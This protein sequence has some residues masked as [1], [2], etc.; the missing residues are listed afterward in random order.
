MRAIGGRDRG[1]SGSVGLDV[2]H[3]GQAP[4]PG[5]GSSCPWAHPT[6][7]FLSPFIRPPDRRRPTRLGPL[8]PVAPRLPAAGRPWRR[9]RCPAAA[10]PAARRRPRHPCRDRRRSAPSARRPAA[11]R[12][13]RLRVDI[14][15]HPGRPNHS[16]ADRVVK[17]PSATSISGAAGSSRTAQPA[18]AR[19]DGLARQPQID[20]PAG[21]WPPD[22]SPRRAVNAPSASRS[23]PAGRAGVAGPPRRPRPAPRCC[24]ADRVRPAGRA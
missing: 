14:S 15:A 23:P 8:V 20:R 21:R 17:M 22:R 12:P 10:P 4:A 11:S 13:R 9:R 7:P 5:R 3:R 2:G 1:G 16:L 24:A 19:P 18:G 6:P